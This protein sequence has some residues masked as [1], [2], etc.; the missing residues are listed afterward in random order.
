M[1]NEENNQQVNN[2]TENPQNTTNEP[3]GFFDLIIT[4]IKILID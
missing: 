1:N 2:Q 4:G 3:K